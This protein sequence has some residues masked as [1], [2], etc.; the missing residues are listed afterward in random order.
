[1]IEGEIWANIWQT[2]CIARICPQTGK[3]VGWVLMH[4]LAHALQVRKLPQ[5]GTPMDVLNGESSL[6]GSDRLGRLL[7]VCVGCGGP[8]LAQRPA[9]PSALNPPPSTLNPKPPTLNP[10]PH[11]T[12]GIAWDASRRRIFVGG[13]YWPRILEIKV[14]AINPNLTA[15]KE[16]ADSCFVG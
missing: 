11:T 14:E 6:D 1:M 2:E 13:K 8:L 5:K 7:R 9:L 12:K 15:N 16:R 3:V 10:Q 4:G